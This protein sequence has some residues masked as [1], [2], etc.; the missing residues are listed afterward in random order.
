MIEA[1]LNARQRAILYRMCRRNLN[2]DG[3]ESGSEMA[4]ALWTS[5]LFTS[6]EQGQ[7]TAMQ[8]FHKGLAER[9]GVTMTGAQCFVPT[10]A[11]RALGGTPT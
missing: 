5:R 7:R 1:K 3:P 10:A 11:G 4:Y 6:A 8:L 9:A 2:V